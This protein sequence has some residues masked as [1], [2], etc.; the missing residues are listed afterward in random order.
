MLAALARIARVTSVPVTADLESGYGM[1]PAEIVERLAQALRYLEAG[2]DCVLPTSGRP[3]GRNQATA[4]PCA[5]AAST[6]RD[7]IGRAR[8]TDGA[9][10]A[11]IAV[12]SITA[13]N[14]RNDGPAPMRSAR[15]PDSS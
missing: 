9:I 15:M 4:R 2:T 8:R 12:T 5:Q 7:S 14:T 11:M 10:D 13:A 6:A 1:A 3:G